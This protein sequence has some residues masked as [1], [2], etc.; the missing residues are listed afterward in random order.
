MK[1]LYCREE[2]NPDHF[3][4]V[5]MYDKRYRV[6]RPFCGLNCLSMFLS[7]KERSFKEVEQMLL[8]V[9]IF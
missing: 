1:C 6:R 7:S 8:E 9:E 2:V 3:I 5:E 4:S